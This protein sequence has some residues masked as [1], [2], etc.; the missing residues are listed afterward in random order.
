[1][2]HLI[3]QKIR[4]IIPSIFHPVL[5]FSFF[6]SLPIIP[7][8][9]DII[10]GTR[11]NNKIIDKTTGTILS[12][13]IIRVKTFIVSQI[14]FETEFIYFKI[15]SNRISKLIQLCIRVL[16]FIINMCQRSTETS[17]FTLIG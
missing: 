7:I 4:I 13:F 8:I 11:P 5:C 10:F 16:S 14:S 9:S 17:F 6:A 12:T 15:T 1:M 2:P 3:C